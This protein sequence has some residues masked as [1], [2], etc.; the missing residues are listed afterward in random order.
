MSCCRA[1]VANAGEDFTRLLQGQ[2]EGT[3]E[4]MLA[5]YNPVLVGLKWH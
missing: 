1:I 5:V 4:S 2:P 3:G